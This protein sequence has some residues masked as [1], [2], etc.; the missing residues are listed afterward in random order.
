MENGAGHAVGFV[1]SNKPGNGN[2]IV[3]ADVDVDVDVDMGVDLIVDLIVGVD[4]VEDVGGF[5]RVD[6]DGGVESD[7]NEQDVVNDVG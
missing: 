7:E 4:E 3:D 6:K 1:D 2:L 5:V